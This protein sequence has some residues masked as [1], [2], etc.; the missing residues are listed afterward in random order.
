M[1]VGAPPPISATRSRRGSR[2]RIPGDRVEAEE[3]GDD[4]DPGVA[5]VDEQALAPRRAAG[6]H[7]PV[8]A[9]VERV[10]VEPVEVLEQCVAA[11]PP[12][13][14][15]LVEALHHRRL[16]ERRQ[17]AQLDRS[18]AD[19]AGEALAIERRVRDGVADERVDALALVRLEPRARPALALGERARQ[20]QAAADVDQPLGVIGR[21]HDLRASRAAA[22]FASG[23]G[24]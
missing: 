16:V 10:V 20:L 24:P 19:E 23:G 14:H 7:H 17:R 22:A 1:W 4:S 18:G 21:S 2:G 3:L 12:V 13:G 5:V 6:R 8:P 15:E 11:Q 9:A